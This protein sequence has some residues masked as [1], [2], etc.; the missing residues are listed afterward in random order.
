MGERGLFDAGFRYARVFKNKE[1]EE[2]FAFKFGFSFM[3]AHDW[4]ATNMD[5]TI[6]SRVDSMNPG[7]YDAVNR[8][9]DEN[10]GATRNN[11]DNAGSLVNKPGLGV[12]HRTGYRETDLVDYDA[13]NIKSN[14]ALHYKVDSLSELVFNSS[15]G[16]GTTIYQGDNRYSLQNI[17]FF[18]NRIEYRQQN[19]FFIPV[20]YTHL[21]AHET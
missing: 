13:Q 6:Q 1:D 8:Y 17:L 14:L 15:F 11:F 16:T 21:R 10:Y 2:K 7:G 18:Q 3:R 9:G 19:K 12:I 4:E 20:S 5:S